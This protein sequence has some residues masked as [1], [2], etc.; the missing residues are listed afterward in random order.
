MSFG[1]DQ[2]HLGITYDQEG[3]HLRAIEKGRVP[4]SGN[5]GLVPSQEAVY[6]LKSKVLGKGGDRRFNGKIIDGVLH[7]PGKI[8]DH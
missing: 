2:I 8:T 5:N 3:E 4:H 1:K 7:L 6:D